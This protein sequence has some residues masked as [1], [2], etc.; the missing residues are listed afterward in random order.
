MSRKPKPK[1]TL[2]AG[3]RAAMFEEEQR[4]RASSLSSIEGAAQQSEETQSV[5]GQKKSEPAPKKQKEKPQTASVKVDFAVSGGS[6]NKIWG[7]CNGPLSQSADISGLFSKL[8]VPCVR[9]DRTEGSR[10]GYVLDVSKIFPDVS[11]DARD[12]ESYNFR[13]T[14]KYVLAA[15][16][17]GARIIF[18]LGESFDMLTPE[19]KLK[20]H[21]NYDKITTVCVNII[22]HYNDY[23]AGGFALG[24]KYFE[25]MSHTDLGRVRQHNTDEEI[26]E[27]YSRIANGIKLYDSSIKVGGMSFSSPSQFVRDFIRYCKKKNAPVDFISVSLYSS[28]P[29]DMGEQMRQYVHILKNSNY[30]DAQII[31]SEWAYMPTVDGKQATMALAYSTLPENAE[32]RKEIF[33][34]QRSVYGAAFVASGLLKMLEHPEIETACLESGE[35]SS[36]W[37]AVC[38]R[39]GLA[40]KPYFAIEAFSRL[41]AGDRLF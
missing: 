13:E 14:D 41:A 15:A 23:F 20:L 30:S 39:F 29:E 18:R 3:Q 12:P 10:S 34:K 19:H 25:V 33:E 16:N 37:C 22:K 17:V 9:F 21:E 26:F 40:K 35:A 36:L 5:S 8:R 38:D 24:I 4:R 1:N 28:S 31:V 27:L 6:I 11:A 2:S 7:M 32:Q